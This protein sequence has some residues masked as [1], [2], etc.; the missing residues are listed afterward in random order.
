MKTKTFVLTLLFSFF[1]TLGYSQSA[2]I[3]A[4][5]QDSKTWGFINLKGEFV[6]EANLI[7]VGEFTT[8]GLAAAFND[9]YYFINTKGET[10]ETQVNDFRLKNFMGFGIRGFSEGLA[11]IQIGKKWGYINTD[12]QM[13]IKNNYEKVSEFRDGKATA[14]KSGNWYI[15]DASGTETLIDIPNLKNVRDFVNGFAIYDTKDKKFGFIN[16]KAEVTIDANFFSLGNFHNGL[17]WAKDVSKKA[18]Y[19]NA[20]GEWIIEPKYQATRNFDAKSGMARVKEN[21][22]WYYIN[23]SGEALKV[24][25][26]KYDDFHDGLARGRKDGKFGFFDN[27][28]TWVVEAAFQGARDFENGYAAAKNNDL[29]GLIDRRGNWVIEPKFIALRD[30]VLVP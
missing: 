26:E 18:G 1:L 21:D 23:K 15:L 20:K 19:I 12:G 25:T 2:L 14:L 9:G 10:L 29:W 5:P 24:E 7:K 22:Q 27:T 28:G 30:V 11:P 8:D 4:K 6:I 3:L 17:A 13:I 16:A